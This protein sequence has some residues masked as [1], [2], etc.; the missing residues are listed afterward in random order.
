MC[1]CFG[2]FRVTS[3]KNNNERV[4]LPEPKRHTACAVSSS[5]QVLSGEG[6]EGGRGEREGGPL[7]W[8]WLGVRG[9]HCPGPCWGGL[10]LLWDLTRVPL[11]HHQ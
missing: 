2:V 7:S 5:W 3:E 4:L 1:T 10:P 8:S 6:M 11:Y 9:Y